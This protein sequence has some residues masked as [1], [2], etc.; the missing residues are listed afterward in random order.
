MSSVSLLGA[1]NRVEVPFIKVTIG[2]YTF[3]VKQRVEAGSQVNGVYEVQKITYPNYVK[4]LQV[5]KI[6]GQ[7]NQY[8]LQFVYPIRPGDDPNFFEKVFSSVSN[9]RKIIF[10][11]GDVNMPDYIYKNEEALITDITDT[12]SMRAA[13]ITYTVKAVSSAT[14]G[15]S[16]SY[17]FTS[18]HEKP[19]TVIKQILYSPKYKLTTLFYGMANQDLVDNLGLIAGDDAA[20]DIDSK[21]NMS[22]V[23]YIKYLVSLMRSS[24]EAGNNIQLQSLYTFTIH[25]EING[26]TS[27]SIDNVNNV[28]TEKLGGPYFKVTKVTKVKDKSD[29]YEINIGY[30]DSN[31]VLSFQV[32]NQENYSIYYNWQGSLD[33]SDYVMRLNDN[34]NWEKEYAPPVSSKNTQYVT[35]NQDKTWWSNVTQYPISATITIKGLLRPATLMEYVRL[36]VIYFGK[37]HIASGLYIVTKQLDSIS[38]QGYRT[39]LSLTKIGGDNEEDYQ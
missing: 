2:D 31:L 23:E 37:K 19:S 38:E 34:G 33:S 15:Y 11:Y 18:C 39:T 13:T 24:S 7:V 8:S 3:G 25:D 30:P 28:V 10:S 6:N 26:S 27:N 5:E 29:A 20:V 16:G 21:L 35:R 17:N 9:T 4:S 1:L 36:N 12:F 14:L 32:Q 22:P